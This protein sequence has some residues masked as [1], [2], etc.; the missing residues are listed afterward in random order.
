VPGHLVEARGRRGLRL[1]VGRIPKHRHRDSKHVV[2][3]VGTVAEESHHLVTQAGVPDDHGGLEQPQDRLRQLAEGLAPVARRHQVPAGLGRVPQ[4]GPGVVGQL[5]G[6][7]YT[8]GAGRDERLA[9][10]GQR[11]HPAQV[12]RSPAPDPAHELPAVHQLTH[13]AVTVGVAQPHEGRR[14]V[15]FQH[16]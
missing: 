12:V 11:R 4:R 3:A 16:R 5:A 8:T 10:P 1:Q 7:R 13:P 14:V 2:R 15:G 6:H 9:Q